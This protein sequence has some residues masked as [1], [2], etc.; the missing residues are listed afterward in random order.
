[1]RAKSRSKAKKK[2]AASALSQSP[3]ATKRRPGKKTLTSAAKVLADKKST[4]AQRSDAASTLAQ[5][6]AYALK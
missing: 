1:M 4:K 2:A 5:A 3:P 6:A